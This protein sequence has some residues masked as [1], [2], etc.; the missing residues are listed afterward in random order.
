MIDHIDIRRSDT[1]GHFSAPSHS[2][3]LV[4]TCSDS[5]KC[6]EKRCFLALLCKVLGCFFFTMGSL[7]YLQD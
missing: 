3:L 5:S 1:V 4:V 6:Q 2:V 7:K